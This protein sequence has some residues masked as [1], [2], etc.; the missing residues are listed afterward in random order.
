MDNPS[1]STFIT[2]PSDNPTTPYLVDIN[3]INCN[4]EKFKSGIWCKHLEAVGKYRVGKANLSARPSFSQALSGLV[5]GIRIR[6]L[7]EAAYWLTY[8][9][10][11]RQ[12]LAG[13]QFRIVR[14]LLIGSAED[15]VSVAVML[16][17]S[18]NFSTLLAK[19][20]DFTLVMAELV[21]ICK[22]PNWWLPYT[23]GHDYIYQGMLGS[24]KMLYAPEIYA[25]EHCLKH[26]ELAINQHDKVDAQY[27]VQKAHECSNAGAIIAHN[28][29]GLASLKKCYPAITLM[30]DIYLHHQHAL[31]EDSNFTCQAVW[32][33]TGGES[34][35]VDQI[36]TVT[37]GEVRAL[38][39]K[40]NATESH[41]IPSW[42]CDG[43]HCAGNDI[44]Y[45]GMW[46]RMNAVS[47]QFNYYGRVNPD[48]PW[49]EDIFYS[50]D[51]LEVASV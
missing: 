3:A 12:R 48:D 6:N 21:R 28:L 45:S 35:V 4:C 47:N 1:A 5:K 49:L 17:L 32:H 8:C 50:I 24:R 23:G 19:D 27:W 40:V 18:E 2:F 44:R 25:L 20:V 26:L 29:L 11:F 30:R 51:G 46:D 42:C 37:R 31:R 16:K 10:G 14:R 7:D 38:I 22:V 34:S 36:E 13:S 39:E 15:G 41:I 43:V 33:L 9:W